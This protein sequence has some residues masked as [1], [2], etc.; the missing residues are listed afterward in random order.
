MSWL[1]AFLGFAVLIVLHELGHFFAAKA[2]GMRVEKFS[3]FFGP[4]VAKTRRG[5]TEYMVGTIPLGGYVKITGMNP[6]EELEPGLRERSYAG[7][8]VWKRIV[9]IAAGPI[10]NVIVAFLL[11]AGVYW[12]QGKPVPA[13]AVTAVE[14]GQ[15]AAGL[16]REDDRILKV[17]TSGRGGVPAASALGDA[18]N[19]RDDELERRTV[20]VRQLISSGGCGARPLGTKGAD[21]AE[22]VAQCPTPQPLSIL[23]DRAGRQQTIE[24]TPKY[25]AARKRYRLGIGFGGALVPIG[26]VEAAGQSVST[27]WTVTTL[28]VQSVIKVVYDPQARK[29]VS[30]VVGGYEATRQ[31]VEISAAQALSVLA[32]ISLSLAIINLFPFLPLDGG[33]IF[34]A[35]IE[36][37]RGGKRVSTAVLE[38]ASIIG[39]VLVGMLFLIG[40]TN[41]IGRIVDGTGFGVR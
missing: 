5:E 29:E 22:Q 41:D 35:V 9:V 6:E 16:L 18:P 30:S 39:L 33:H 25:D 27:M 12:N 40:V 38:R 4:A 15:A 26:P 2:V 32:L 34:W 14:P 13:V 10:V 8:P 7:S 20:A 11:L 24:V 23:I 17:S 31:S 1:L 28:T 21:G 36:K 37:L 19:L 3:L